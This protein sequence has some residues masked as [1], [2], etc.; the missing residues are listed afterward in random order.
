[1]EHAYP[2]RTMM[3]KVDQIE[4]LFAPFLLPIQEFASRYQM[5][6][7]FVTYQQDYHYLLRWETQHGS[8]CSITLWLATSDGLFTLRVQCNLPY[9]AAGREIATLRNDIAASTFLAMLEEAREWGEK[10]A[11]PVEERVNLPKT[12]I[13]STYGQT[14][15]RKPVPLPPSTWARW[16]AWPLPTD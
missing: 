7:Q 14:T 12:S 4:R 8:M 1:M 15:T 6:F 11:Q 13:S 3:K 9:R 16:V 2:I 5:S 10:C